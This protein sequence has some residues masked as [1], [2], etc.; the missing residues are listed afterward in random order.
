M[1]SWNQIG[2][3]FILIATRYAILKV[4]D[5]YILTVMR[6]EQDYS[7]TSLDVFTLMEYAEYLQRHHSFRCFEYEEWKRVGKPM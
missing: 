3:V 7:A 1:D 4:G 5:R 2:N 6:G